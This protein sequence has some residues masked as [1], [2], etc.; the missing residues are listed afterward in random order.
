MIN[1]KF[2]ATLTALI[3]IVFAICNFNTNKSITENWFQTRG[4]QRSKVTPNKNG[5]LYSIPPYR[6]NNTNPNF[7]SNCSIGTAGFANV[8]RNIRYNPPAEQHMARPRNNPMDRQRR[9]VNKQIKEDYC[10][11]TDDCNKDG[12]QPVKMNKDNSLMSGDYSNG[13]YNDLVN[14]LDAAGGQV[15]VHEALPGADMN[16]INALGEV[17][18]VVNYNRIMFAN[19]NSR[20]RA[21]GDP[22]RG[23]LPITPCN[24]GWFQVSVNPNNDL[25]AGAMNVMGGVTNETNNATSTLIN[26]EAGETTIGGVNLSDQQLATISAGTDVNVV[27]GVS[28]NTFQ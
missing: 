10:G 5:Q 12:S 18:N 3:A 1:G 8:C 2:L 6:I 25:Q 26:S 17:Q 7:Q 27:Q 20:L 23:D 14:Q 13:N 9:M 21:Q 16:T 4:V 15:K 19:P 24:T 28:F 11:C 22:I